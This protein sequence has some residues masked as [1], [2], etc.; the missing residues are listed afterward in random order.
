MA[1]AL[2]TTPGYA[3]ASP[4]LVAAGGTLRSS[5]GG[6]DQELLRFGDRL[7][8]EFDLPPMKAAV[9][10]AWLAA[11]LRAKVEGASV[12][13]QL[14]QIGDGPTGKTGTAASGAT[15]LTVNDA[16]GIVV[17]QRFSA[18]VGGVS[19]LHFVTGLAG[20]TVSVAPRLRV[21]LS[22]T[23]L[24]FVAPVIE[25]TLAA[26]AWSEGLAEVVGLS[27]SVTEAR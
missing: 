27:F 17:G 22:A 26:P 15:A 9:A 8:V 11:Q 2:P 20:T 13:M 21:A 5:L 12:R 23:A 25:G 4:R 6:P 3:K 14:A 10:A 19:Y 7:A 16:A 1:L 24:E 18:I